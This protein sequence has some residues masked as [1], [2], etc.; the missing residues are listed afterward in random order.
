MTVRVSEI[1]IIN[2]LGLKFYR[3]VSRLNICKHTFLHNNNY[4]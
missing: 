1:K 4:K 3:I 2:R